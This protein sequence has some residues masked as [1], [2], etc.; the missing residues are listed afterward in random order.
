MGTVPSQDKKDR[1]R[2]LVGM[3]VLSRHHLIIDMG[4]RRIWMLP[5]AGGA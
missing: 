3:A 5:R 4:R 2:S 1:C